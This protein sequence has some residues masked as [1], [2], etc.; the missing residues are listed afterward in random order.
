MQPI[1][2]YGLVTLILLAVSATAVLAWDGPKDPKKDDG[3]ATEV[4]KLDPPAKSERTTPRT[5]GAKPNTNQNG[6]APSGTDTRRG[7][8]ASDFGVPGTSGAPSSVPERKSPPPPSNLL[9]TA[10]DPAPD[11]GL[12][13]NPAGTRPAD[14]RAKRDTPAPWESNGANDPKVQ[15]PAG[16]GAATQPKGS[17]PLAAAPPVNGMAPNAGTRNQ[18]APAL[19]T[20]E[21][22]VRPTAGLSS[23]LQER[24]KGRPPPH[25]ATGL[26]GLRRREPRPRPW[27]ARRR[28]EAR[29]PERDAHRRGAQDATPRPRRTR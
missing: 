22:V 5:D 29:A 27:C 2:R 28:T 3:G 10:N 16:G 25:G 4:S 6:K 8:T 14:D 13:A 9:G 26:A 11:A 21:L 7:S 15:P 24:S 19:P 17:A 20:G 18:D 1:E 12:G 23:L